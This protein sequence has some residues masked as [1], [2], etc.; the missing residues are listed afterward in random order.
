MRLHPGHVLVAGG[1]VDHHAVAVDAQVDDQVVDHPAILVGHAAVEGLAGFLQALYVVGQQAL[2]V[3]LGLRTGD[4]DHGHVGN[5][6]HAAV[7][8]YLVVLLDLRSIVQGH[9]PTA[10]I[11]DLRAKCYMQVVERGAQSH[12]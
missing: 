8:T 6:E 1:G 7:A 11:D 10:E 4:V 5:V 12:G 3:L 2:Q 9:V